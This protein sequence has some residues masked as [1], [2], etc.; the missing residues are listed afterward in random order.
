MCL[1]IPA[2]VEQ[3]DSTAGTAVV[4]IDKVRSTVSTALLEELA[5]GDYLLIHVGFALSKI[6]EEEARNT[7]AL[8]AEAGLS[9]DA[10]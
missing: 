9:G 10:P 5:I 1:A 7:L 4:T 6:S 2:R 8:I 3:I